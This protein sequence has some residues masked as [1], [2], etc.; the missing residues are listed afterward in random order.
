[1]LYVFWFVADN[2]QTVDH[3]QRIW[4]LAR[5]LFHTGVLQRW[6]YVS[7]S[8]LCDPGNEDANFERVKRLIAASVPE[9]Q[10]PPESVGVSAV[11]KQ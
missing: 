7:Y 6:A 11:A 5:D 1:L 4:W 8:S 10:V 3:W 2:E 9:F